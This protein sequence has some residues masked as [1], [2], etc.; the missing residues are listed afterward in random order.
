MNE[1]VFWVFNGWGILFFALYLFSF[2][3]HFGVTLKLGSGSPLRI[4]T[5]ALNWTALIFIFILSGW[6]AGMISFPIGFILGSK[7]GRLIFSEHFT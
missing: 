6:I 2:V 7:L 1:S 4:L 5:G 3:L